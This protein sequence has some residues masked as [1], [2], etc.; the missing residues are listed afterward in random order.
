MATPYTRCWVASRSWNW[1]RKC[2]AARDPFPTV[3]RTLDALHLASQQFLVEQGQPVALASYD[4]RIT[5]LTT[6][7]RRRFPA[8]LR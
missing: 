4:E 5:P 8:W 3:V 6:P 2:S 7:A 1:F